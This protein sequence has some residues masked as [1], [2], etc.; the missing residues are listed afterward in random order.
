M[1]KGNYGDRTKDILEKV[2]KQIIECKEADI[3]PVFAIT[4]LQEAMFE[5]AD[6]SLEADKELGYVLTTSLEKFEKYE[7]DLEESREER[8]RLMKTIAELT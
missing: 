6:I 2:K 1:I 7:A 4:I 5:I 3:P 8:I